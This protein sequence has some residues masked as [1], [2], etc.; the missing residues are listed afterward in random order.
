MQNVKKA[1][2]SLAAVGALVITPMATQAEMAMEEGTRWTGDVYSTLTVASGENCATICDIELQCKA[3]TWYEKTKVCQLMNPLPTQGDANVSSVVSAVKICTGTEGVQMVEEPGNLDRN[4]GDIVR[5][6]GIENVGRC[7]NMCGNTPDCIAFTWNRSNLNCWLKHTIK[8]QIPSS[9]GTTGVKGCQRL[10][11]ESESAKA[12]QF[13]WAPDETQKVG[14]EPNHALELM[15]E[16]DYPEEDTVVVIGVGAR[17]TD[18][19]FAALK[20][21][22]APVDENCNIDY[23]RK[24]VKTA[25]STTC[26]EAETQVDPSQVVVGVGMRVNSDNLTTLTV[27][28]QTLDPSTCLLT[29][30]LKEYRSGSE[31]DHSLEAF[32]YVP[33]STNDR[34]IVIGVGARANN[35]NVTTLQLPTGKIQ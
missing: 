35:S 17:V 14:S 29:G 25:G 3:M 10:A 1:I 13:E 18:D 31:P 28:G 27:W 22:I 2:G 19:N 15:V 33:P 34:I 20:L 26:C 11:K 6:G 23:S 7:M 4:G 9:V 24:G 12:S 8:P 16:L 21:N 32:W 5:I 30:P